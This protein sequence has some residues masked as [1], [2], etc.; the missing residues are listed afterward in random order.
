MLFKN[1]LD[2]HPL[3]HQ[4]QKMILNESASKCNITTVVPNLLGPKYQLHEFFL[5]VSYLRLSQRIDDTVEG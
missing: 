2:G 3:D 1:T 5:L 4:I